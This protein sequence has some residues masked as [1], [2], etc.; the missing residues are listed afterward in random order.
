M[1]GRS[2]RILV[3]IG[4]VVVVLGIVYTVALVR[5]KAKLREAYAALEQDGRPL[6]LDDVLPPEVPDEQNAA[7]L[8]EKAAAMLEA[9]PSEEEDNLLEELQRLARALFQEPTDPDRLARQQQDVARL[10]QRMAQ[11]VVTTALALVEQGTQRPAC[12][13]EYDQA[14][15]L[16]DEKPVSNRMRTLVVAL[17]ARARLEAEAGDLQKA[18]DTIQT[19]LRFGHTL[20]HDPIALDPWVRFAATGHAC[21]VIRHVCEIAPP[22]EHDYQPIEQLLTTADDVEPF[23]RFLDAER[24]SRG[25]GIFSLPPDELYEVLREYQNSFGGDAPEFFNRLVFRKITFAPTFVADHA[26]YLQVMR[27]SVQML[28]G[29]FVS[30]D[31]PAYQEI[32]KLT[33]RYGLTARIAPYSSGMKYIHSRMAADLRMVRAGLALL[34]FKRRHGA[35]PPALDALGLEDLIDPFDQKPLRYRPEAQGFVVYSVDED[36]KDNGGATRQPRQKTD[37]DRVWR[38]GT[39]DDQAD[40]NG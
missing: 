17:G 8:Y 24:L 37:Y 29:P 16:L 3:G 12:R 32:G 4:L 31:A 14:I 13:F 18:W 7:L 38:F 20:R 19:Q 5:A 9:E 21:R 15:G 28:E 1:R 11:D 39:P 6:S 23:V 36:Q 26:A 10:K 40:D 35:F 22:D 27:R 30:R 34:R 33:R 2:R 25:E